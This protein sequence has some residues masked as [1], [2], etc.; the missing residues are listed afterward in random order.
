MRRSRALCGEGVAKRSGGSGKQSAVRL[1]VERHCLGRRGEV[2]QYLG[3]PRRCNW[4]RCDSPLSSQRSRLTAFGASSTT[5]SQSF[6]NRLVPR[7]ADGC[8]SA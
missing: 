4:Q 6:P 1:I 8:A 7:K 3:R 2:V 5:R